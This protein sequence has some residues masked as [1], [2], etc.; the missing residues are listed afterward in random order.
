[1]RSTGEAGEPSPK[2]R[3]EE[4]PDEDRAGAVSPPPPPRAAAEAPPREAPAKMEEGR[5]DLNVQ[6]FTSP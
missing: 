4:T 2:K 1:M 3:Q 6:T 5:D